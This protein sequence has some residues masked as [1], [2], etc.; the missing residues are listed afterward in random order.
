MKSSSPNNLFFDSNGFSKSD[1]F[2]FVKTS[3]EFPDL[4][5]FHISIVSFQSN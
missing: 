5:H 4:L 3:L 1:V 2:I